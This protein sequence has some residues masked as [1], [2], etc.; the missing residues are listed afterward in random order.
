M[1]ATA[2]AALTIPSSFLR[3]P[4]QRLSSN[5]SQRHQ[6]SPQ[7]LPRLVFCS[8]LCPYPYLACPLFLNCKFKNTWM[9]FFQMF[10]YFP[11]WVFATWLEKGCSLLAQIFWEENKPCHNHK[12][13][14]S[15]QGHQGDVIVHSGVNR[16]ESSQLDKNKL[17]HDNA[18]H[19]SSSSSD[20]D[21]FIL[22]VDQR[23]GMKVQSHFKQPSSK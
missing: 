15:I 14:S 2:A 10:K 16:R 11:I 4:W 23:S 18:S 13:L 17:F 5:K 7:Q 1:T 6:A 22:Y 12:R 9:G 20:D 3:F 19:A 21:E 8:S